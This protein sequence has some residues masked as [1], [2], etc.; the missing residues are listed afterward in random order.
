M[1]C[2][3]NAGEIG[4]GQIVGTEVVTTTIVSALSD[5]QPQVRTTTT[6]VPLCQVSQIADGKL[7]GTNLL[8]LSDHVLTA[9]Q[10]PSPGRHHTVC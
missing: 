7:L 3:G 6:G 1:E 5:G 10:R 9:A 8:V 4:D 2:G